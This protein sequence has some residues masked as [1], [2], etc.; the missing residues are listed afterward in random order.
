MAKRI[1][2]RLRATAVGFVMS[3]AVALSGCV[4]PSL[5]ITPGITSGPTVSDLVDHVACEVGRAYEE[6]AADAPPDLPRDKLAAWNSRQSLWRKL[7]NYSFVGAVDLTLAVTD[8]DSAGYTYSR[9][10]PLTGNGKSAKPYTYSGMGSTSATNNRTLALG[11]QVNGTQI[12]NV[13]Q[14]YNLDVRRIVDAYENADIIK[15]IQSAQLNA[16]NPK[17][18]YC[19][20]RTRGPSIGARLESQLQGNLALPETIE[21]GLIA[22]DRSGVYNIY[23]S[24]GPTRFVD[25]IGAPQAFIAHGPAGGAGLGT[26]GSSGGGA[27]SGKVSFASKV[28]FSITD[29]IGGGPTY[30]LLVSKLSGGS[31]GGGGQPLNFSRMTED[32]F[33]V[34]FGATCMQPKGK[35]SETL[36]T[37]DAMISPAAPT[38]APVAPVPAPP[39]PV[40]PA[41]V[42]PAPALPAPVALAP[43]L[44]PPAVLGMTVSGTTPD[45]SPNGASYNFAFTLSAAAWMS[46]QTGGIVPTMFSAGSVSS[47]LADRIVLK[48]GSGE[49]AEGAVLWTG[50]V[51]ADGRYDLRGIVK[52][53]ITGNVVGQIWLS[54]DTKNL[55]NK[56]SGGITIQ[57]MPYNLLDHLADNTVDED[58]WSTVLACDAVTATQI[59]AVQDDLQ[60]KTLLQT[61]LRQ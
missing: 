42:A 43:A 45:R 36:A 54:G 8:T 37:F 7:Y 38:P 57:H 52:S 6:R 60:N 50:Y 44:P 33:T 49:I 28:D 26:G 9:V 58:Y 32:S 29:G 47:Q 3:F 27:S 4:G 59:Q 15:T 46:A 14:D 17:F 53:Q 20:P 23:G 10:T 51:R 21:A 39:A 19:A 11:L 30:A 1:D 5:R 2:W 34:T 12:R 56:S 16:N 48:D 61:Y 25:I 18:P 22:L 40:A 13:E 24:G 55:L 31:S 41:P 35:E